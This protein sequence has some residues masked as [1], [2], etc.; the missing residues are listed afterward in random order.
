[1]KKLIFDKEETRNLMNMLQSEDS[2]NHV[3]AFESLKNVDFK[4][5]IGEIL[6]MYKYS[7]RGSG[8]W[9]ELCLPVYNKLVKIIPEKALTSPA[10]LSLIT[11]EKGSSSSVELF[12]ECF[13][14]D[15]TRMLSSIGYPTENFEINIKLKDNGQSTKS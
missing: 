11:K 2:D 7:G 3:I 1:M 8:D 15:M 10:T 6:V 9:Q 14:R 4:K 12:M 13:I 5:Y